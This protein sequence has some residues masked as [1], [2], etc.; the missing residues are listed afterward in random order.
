MTEENV[1][2]KNICPSTW[3]VFNIQHAKLENKDGK[4]KIGKRPYWVR[5]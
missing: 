5:E 3:I 4:D 1:R 2:K